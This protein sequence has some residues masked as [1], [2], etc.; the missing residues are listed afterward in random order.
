MTEHILS[1]I[2]FFPLIGMVLILF[3]PKTNVSAV[4]GISLLVTG[5]SSPP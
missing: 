1:W 4:K 3:V 5:I 2:T